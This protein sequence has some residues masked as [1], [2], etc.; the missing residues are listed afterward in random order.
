MLQLFYALAVYALA[1]DITYSIRTAV[2][3]ANHEPKKTN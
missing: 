1:N 2:G 3:L